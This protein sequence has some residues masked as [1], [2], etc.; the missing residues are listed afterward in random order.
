MI[1]LI[2]LLKEI[3]AEQNLSKQDKEKLEQA[4]A[5][6][7]TLNE[8]EEGSLTENKI[9]DVANKLKKIGLSIGLFTLLAGTNPTSAQ[10]KAIDLA[11]GQTTTTQTIS[12]TK[13]NPN[14][15]VKDTNDIKK[16]QMVMKAYRKYTLGQWKKGEAK[17]MGTKYANLTDEERKSIESRYITDATRTDEDGKNGEF[18]SNFIF[19]LAFLKDLNTGAIENLG[20]EGNEALQLVKKSGLTGQ[21]IAEWNQFAKWMKENKYAGDKKMNN[22]KYSNNVLQQYKGN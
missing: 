10:T 8:L 1:K 4:K 14:F 19:P 13:T 11:K 18:T 17:I 15:W 21:Q 6:L 5:L 22:L 3:E 12:T 2:T 16:I 7:A 20:L 9:T